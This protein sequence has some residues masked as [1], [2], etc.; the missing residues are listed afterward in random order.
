[1]A[2]LQD[3]RIELW[4]YYW[5]QD[6]SYEEARDF[7]G[8]RQSGDKCDFWSAERNLWNVCRASSL[9]GLTLC[10]SGN[11]A[12]T[13]SPTYPGQVRAE[14]GIGTP[15]SWAVCL[16]ALEQVLHPLV[17]AIGR[18]GPCAFPAPSSL[19]PPVVQGEKPSPPAPSFLAARGDCVPQLRPWTRK[20]NPDEQTVW[21][22]RASGC[23]TTGAGC[24]W[25]RA[26]PPSS[27]L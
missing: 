21:S 19:P 3:Y 13:K 15:E 4:L 18:S 7:W 22:E 16:C 24:G 8:Q 27:L 9:S 25:C 17:R 12:I 26:F 5:E 2:L 20:Q 6:C 10:L 14:Q 1:M 11:T 23:P